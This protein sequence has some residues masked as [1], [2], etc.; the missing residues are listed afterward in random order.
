MNQSFDL[1]S[2]EAIIFQN[3]QNQSQ[4]TRNKLM[5]KKHLKVQETKEVMKRDMWQVQLQLKRW[6]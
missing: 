5:K 6:R 4:G 1:R 2:G 3:E